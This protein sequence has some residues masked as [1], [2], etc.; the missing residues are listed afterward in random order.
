[1][2]GSIALTY[3]GQTIEIGPYPTEKSLAPA[4]EAFGMIGVETDMSGSHDKCYDMYMYIKFDK[5]WGGD[6]DLIGYDDSNLVLDNGGLSFTSQLVERHN[7]GV[8]IKGPGG[9]FFRQVASTPTVSVS[10]NGFMANC[11]ADDCSFTHD[12]ALTPSL[13]SVA[14]SGDEL[15]ITGAGFTTEPSD[16]LVMV[17][18]LMCEVTAA[19][20]TSITCTLEAGSAGVYDVTVVVKSLGVATQPAAGQLTHEVSMSIFSNSPSEGSIGGGTTITVEGTGFPATMEG[21]AGGSVSIAGSECKV[22]STSV[23][24]FQCV[25][26]ANNAG[27]RRKRAA[28]E[29][30]ITIGSSTASGGSFNYDAALTPSVSSVSPTSSS[31]MGGDV[32]TIEGTAFGYTW[33]E[34]L[35]GDAKCT[36]LTWFDAI[37]T[38]TLPANSHGDYPVHVSVPNQGYA[39]VSSVSTINYNFVVTD[40]TPRKGSNMGGTKV[41]VT[42]SGFGD[43]SDVAVKFGDAFDCMVESCSD[44]EIV[45]VTKKVSSVHQISN[46]GRHPSYGPGYVWSPK[47]ITIQPGDMVDWIW[48]LQVA[49]EDTGISVQQTSSASSNDWDGKGF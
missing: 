43:C 11:A 20:A 13:D 21:W 49:S 26:S 32:L 4:L 6:V 3:N 19:T 28:S 46:G 33:G 2:S 41:K 7:G 16:F 22:V 10:V 8:M 42:G 36:I 37:I 30:S 45:C 44:T 39:D 25:T 18:D 17:G 1:M 40:V 9:D 5:S 24:E 14:S 35:L 38:C 15:T 31:P 23:G 29:I 27:G 34:V 47:E 48:N 12:A